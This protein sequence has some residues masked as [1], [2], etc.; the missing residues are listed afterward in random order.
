[1]KV[2]HLLSKHAGCIGFGILAVFAAGLYADVTIPKIDNGAVS[3]TLPGGTELNEYSWLEQSRDMIHWEPVARDYGFDWENTFPHQVDISGGSGNQVFTRVVDEQ[4]VYFRLAAA[5]AP[6]LT[7]REV[8]SRFLQQSTFGPTRVMINSFPGVDTGSSF[9]E[10]PYAYFE[11]WI[12]QQIAIP[13]FSHRKFFRERSNPSFKETA[14]DTKYEVGHNPQLGHQLTYNIGQTKYYP[15]A[16]N[17]S[18]PLNDVEFA[19]PETKRLVWYQAAVTAPDALRQ[20]IAWAMSQFFV[21]GEDGSNQLT[22]T[23]RYTSFYDIFVRHAFGN[24]RDILGEVT[25]HPAMGY[26]LTFVDN[27]GFHVSG[28]Y[29][30]ENYAREVM[31]LYTIGLWK[32]NLDGSLILDETGKLMPTYTNDNIVEF[33]KIF[34]GL[35]KDYLRL[36]IEYVGGNYVDPMRMQSSWHDFSEKTLLDGSKLKA[37]TNNAAGAL[38][39]INLFLQHLFDH[40]NTAPFVSRF[41]I[42]RLT[43]SNPSPNYI[44]SVSDAFSTGLYNGTGTGVRGDMTAVI[45]A[46]FLHPEAR[47]PSLAFDDA[48]GKLREPLVRMLHYARAFEITSLQT[49]GLFPFDQM[50]QVFAQSPY[51]SPSVFNFYQVDY[52]PLGD[53]LD[54]GIYS[55]EFQIHTDL[56]S[57]SLANG[58]KTLVDEGIVDLIGRRGYSQASLDLSYEIGMADDVDALL[59]HLDL[60]ITAGRLSQEN[61]TIISDIISQ[62]PTG[63][64]VNNTA[65][66]RKALSLF[67]LLPEFNVIY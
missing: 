63:N 19:A 43:V 62:M 48:H 66:V 12:D 57:L 67:C 20:R 5:S 52:Q 30:D 64:D 41:L 33:A 10:P 65:R 60:M 6:A 49:Y 40:P 54:R 32:L 55:P 7:N 59:D 51:E 21:L 44:A 46:I 42:Q 22:H 37:P 50:D 47:S 14:S 38:V 53:I 13:L 45:K 15:P 23:E 8:V 26:Y 39:E 16:V 35:R 2:T 31:Q 56:T 36:N 9:N 18:R 17:P 4:T 61:R 24:F 28:T 3:F 25:F 34:T 58:I 27:K 29:P 11:Q 1:M